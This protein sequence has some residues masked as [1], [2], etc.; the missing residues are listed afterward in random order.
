MKRFVNKVFNGDALDLLRVIPTTSVDS[1]IADAMYGTAKSFAYEWGLDPA[2]GDSMKHWQ[3][4]HPFYQQCR[5]VLKLG[6][7]LAWAQGCRFLG[8]MNDWFGP[9]RIWPLV[10]WAHHGLIAGAH[11]WV[12]QTKEQQPIEL[13]RRNLVVTVDRSA[14]LPLRKLHLS[15]KP[16]EEMA[17]LLEELTK[18][19]QIVL[20]C[21]CGLGSTLVAAQQLG[22]RWIGCDKSKTYCQ[23]AMKRLAEFTKQN[24]A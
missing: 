16:V 23:I 19:G 10:R 11:I 3:Y 12:V 18:P 20:D 13:P 22:R 4:H 8:Q 9:H 15:P 2:K 14:Y 24:V 7:V 5:R 6:G 1:V 21:F 17:F